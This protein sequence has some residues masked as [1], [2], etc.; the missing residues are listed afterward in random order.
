[1]FEY[2]QVLARMRQ[3]DSDRD[4]ARSG[5][6]GRK[7]AAQLRELAERRGWLSL[8]MVL[9]DDAEI[10]QLVPRP[11][12]A[13]SSVS[14][15]Q[16]H[17]EQ[18]GEW[19]DA[20]VQ[21]TTIHAALKRNHGYAGSY[22][23]VR[24]MVRAIHATRPAPATMVLSFD[25][26]EA[27]QVDFG[28]GP[29]ITD[30]LSGEVIRTWVFVMTLC[31]SRHQYAELVRDQ[32]VATWLGCHRRAFEWFNGVP[33]RTII[34]NPKCA[35]TRACAHD[36]VV[37]RAYAE[38]AEG[39]GFKIDALPPR[40]PAK[41][42]I[43]ESGVKYVKASFMPLRSFRSLAD[44][45]EQLRQWVMAEAGNRV[46]GTTRELPL[47][48]FASV[49]KPL[50]GRLPDVPPEPAEWARLT[51]NRTCHVQHRH[52]LYSV[53]HVLVGKTVWLRAAAALVKVFHEHALVATHPRLTKPGSRS[54][55]PDHLP[56]EARAWSIAT[57]EWCQQQA[58]LVGSQCHALV[59][60]LLTDR[61]VE[62]L[63]PVQAL[64]RLRERYG[65]QRLEAACTRALAFG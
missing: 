13:V 61:V 36:P 34:D 55:V 31:W 42:G 53:P 12:P 54:T 5:L 15:L 24:R 29:E 20:G 46:H 18:I 9:P 65:P 1:M 57:P 25:P 62:K 4:I 47:L 10:A 35:I 40:D 8:Q 52:C 28:A 33:A 11:K 14:S 38:C 27:A 45:N 41:K 44:G 21:G 32:T 50:L 19:V 51:V 48:R 26:G 56:P 49:E 39:Y 59:T 16:A 64:L 7:K 43:V 23:S 2:R 58:A 63:R 3:G 60:R 37:Q 17:R 30:A 6:M 22:S